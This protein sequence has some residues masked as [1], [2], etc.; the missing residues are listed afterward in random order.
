MASFYER[1]ILPGLI[2]CACRAPQIMDKRAALVPA[3][4]GRVLEL[5]AGSGLNFALY[6]PEEVSVA[7]G[8]EP[9]AELRALARQAPK[10]AGLAVEIVPGAAENLPFESATFDTVLTTFT[11]CSVASLDQA[12]REA[13]RVLKPSGRL[14]FC[15][16]GLSPDKSVA[17]WQRGLDPFWSRLAGGCHLCRA[18]GAAVETA[19]F[20]FEKVEQTYLP[21][22]PKIVGWTQ[23]GS[24]R[25]R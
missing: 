13:R 23:W 9:S 11:L 17:R 6:K 3:A 16:H 20:A 22:T 25:P 18:I 2:A 10:A 15:E 24:A 21:A 14:L 19:G 1:R 12:L 7:I 5:G 4:Q 8:L